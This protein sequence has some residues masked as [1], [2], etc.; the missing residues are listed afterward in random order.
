MVLINSAEKAEWDKYPEMNMDIIFTL[1]EMRDIV[2]TLKHMA[3]G[4]KNLE[5]ACKKRS[6]QIIR[7]PWDPK[8]QWET[9]KLYAD[10]HL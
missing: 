8:A 10:K 9:G 7:P 3:S 6:A 2:E 1:K 4:L 5:A